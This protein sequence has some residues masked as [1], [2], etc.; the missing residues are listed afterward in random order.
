MIYQCTLVLLNLV[1]TTIL[2]GWCVAQSQIPVRC[3][4]IPHPVFAWN[5]GS[6][7]LNHQWHSSLNLF[8]VAM[9]TKQRKAKIF[10]SPTVR[11]MFLFLWLSDLVAAFVSTLLSFSMG[12]ANL[13]YE[14][15]TMKW[16]MPQQVSE[17]SPILALKCQWGPIVV[18]C[19]WQALRKKQVGLAMKRLSAKDA[20]TKDAQTLSCK[21]S[22]S[23]MKLREKPP[24]SWQAKSIRYTCSKFI[25]HKVFLC[26]SYCFSQYRYLE[27]DTCV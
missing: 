7:E 2:V 8:A 9:G 14:V 24:N 21:M 26:I 5:F 15:D 12:W 1:D 11:R 20:R 6:S 18:M 4:Q 10:L 17:C 22:L 23:R 19:L 27:Y 16:C 25:S 3:H 13:G